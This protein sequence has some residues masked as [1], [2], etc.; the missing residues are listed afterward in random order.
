MNN[1]AAFLDIPSFISEE[2]EGDISDHEICTPPSSPFLSLYESE[3]GDISVDPETEQYTVFLNELYD[4]EFDEALSTL[5]SE[6]AA[7]REAQ[8]PYKQEDPQTIGHQA[9]RLLNQ[10]FAPSLQR[11]R[12]CWE[13]WLTNSASAIQIH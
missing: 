6:A 2:G 11:L 3:E 4:E 8:F 1:Q 13:P 5:V 10:H 12:P 7:I 9:E